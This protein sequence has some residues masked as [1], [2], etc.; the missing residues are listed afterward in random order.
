MLF[1]RGRVSPERFE[2]GK[3]NV[4]LNLTKICWSAIYI[5]NLIRKRLRT[6]LVA[7][8]AELREPGKV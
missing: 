4:S 8:R 7:F 3:K 2:L 5:R 1:M 6:R